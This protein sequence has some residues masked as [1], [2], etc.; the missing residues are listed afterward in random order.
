MNRLIITTMQYAHAHLLLLAL[1]LRLTG[2]VGKAPAVRYA[3]C[4]AYTSCCILKQINIS[5]L[6]HYII[7]L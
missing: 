1:E 3:L 7:E 6:T 2:K 5:D 4:A